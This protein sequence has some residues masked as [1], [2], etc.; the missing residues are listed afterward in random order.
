MLNLLKVLSITILLAF[1]TSCG[2]SGK[3]LTVVS[4]SVSPPFTASDLSGKTLYMVSP[5]S[6]QIVSLGSSA[7][8]NGGILNIGAYTFARIQTEPASDGTALYWL[9]YDQKDTEKTVYRIYFDQTAAQSY[10]SSIFTLGNK[11]VFA[12]AV[13]GGELALAGTVTNLAGTAGVEG[14][15]D[16]TGGA[17]SFNRPLQITTDGVNF[18][19]ADY[20]NNTIRKID[21]SGVVTTFAGDPNR[22]GSKDGIGAAATFSRPFGITSDGANLYVADS[23]NYVIRKIVIATQEVTTLAGIE[24]Y[25]G[26]VDDIGD[27]ARFHYIS[28]ITTDGTNLYVTDSYN[29]IR[30]VVISTKMV[31]TLAGKPGTDDSKDGTGE[32]ARF[33][34]PTGITTDGTNLYVTDYNNRTIRK[35]SIATGEVKTIIGNPDV[36]PGTT[37]ATGSGTSAIFY[38]LHGITSDGIYL[39]VTDSYNNTIY[40]IHKTS[41]LVTKLAGITGKAGH[42]NTVDGM[43]TFDTPTGITTDGKSLYITDSRNNTIRKL[44]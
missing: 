13:Q 25:S 18:Y 10:I 29:T 12:G 33:S 7:T 4:A 24:G 43:P 36:A 39:Y 11:A 42:D 40:K 37:D 1:L 41:L 8:V 9:V 2:G 31:T 15:A 17:A 23:D 27:G 30:K 3:K 35:V 22:R 20:Y 21:H 28:G 32:D 19:V 14:Q 38:Q 6:N 26:S 5:V 34:L 44:E 16:G